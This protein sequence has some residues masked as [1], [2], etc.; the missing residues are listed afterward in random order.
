MSQEE[1]P[2]DVCVLGEAMALF[3]ASDGM[4]LR[5]SRAFLRSVAGS[6]SNVAVGLGRLGY[7][8]CMYGRVGRDPAAAWV[9]GTLRESGVCTCGITEDPGAPTGILIRD[10][11]GGRKVTVSYHRQGSAGS[12]LAMDDLRPEH[13]ARSRALFV[14]GIT[15]MLSDSA[16]A[17]VL[18]AAEV[19][20]ENSVHIIFDPNIRARLGG[21]E[22]WRHR[23]APMCELAD[24]VILGE[25]ESQVLWPGHP[26]GEQ[27]RGQQTVVVRLRDRT[28]RAYRGGRQV[29]ATARAVNV[30]DPVGAGDAFTSGWISGWLD[31][32][33]Q[34]RCLSRAHLM[35][36]LAVST[37]G[38][39][40]G[41]PFAADLADME[42]AQEGSGDDVD[43]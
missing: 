24:T 39:I 7:R 18:S 26:P 11:P 40:E 3:V 6:E 32:H 14:S 43:R 34:A 31:G 17:C 41:L 16:A 33:E 35:A 5:T 30:T 29:A 8:V 2:A 42:A 15:S 21:P 1:H 27:R 25:A 23:L 20:R 4:P 37:L 10:A 13:I 22:A 36:S 12:R 38:D 28:A 19:A 9:R